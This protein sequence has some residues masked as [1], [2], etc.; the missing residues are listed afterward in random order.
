MKKNVSKAKFKLMVWGGIF[1]GLIA[2]C[3]IYYIIQTRLIGQQGFTT[4]MSLIGFLAVV[5]GII[6]WSVGLAGRANYMVEGID[7]V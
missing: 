3:I 7:D 6:G 2:N 5:T 1:G 4:T